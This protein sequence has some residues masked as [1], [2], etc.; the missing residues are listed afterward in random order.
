MFKRIFTIA[1]LYLKTTYS[2]R[3]TL[4]FSLAMPLLFTFV[5]AQAMANDGPGE[6]QIRITLAVVDEDATA[7]SRAFIDRLEADPSV[8][9]RP[10]EKEAA[11]EE[12][13]D[14]LSAAVLIPSGFEAGLTAGE[15]VELLFYQNSNEISE[16]Q[17]LMEAV[18]A[19]AGELAGSFAAADIATRVAGRLGMFAESNPQVVDSYRAEAFTNAEVEWEAGAPVVVE[20]Q[21]V[22]RLEQGSS[23]PNGASQSSPG[24]LVM[25]ALF[26]TFGGGA[27]LLVERDE[28][29]LRRLLVMP[30]GKGTLMAGKMLGIYLGALVQMAIMVLA[31]QFA[32]GVEWGQDPAALVVMLLAYGL[33]GTSLGLLLAAL[34][35]TAAQV[36]AAGTIIMMALSS[37]GGAWWPIEI[38][39]RYMQSLALALPTGWAM[40]GFHDIIT[41]GL[42]LADILLETAVLVG[43]AALFFGIGIWRFKYE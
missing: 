32:F 22:S 21:T 29:T 12:L 23:I 14:V 4:I 38:V 8:N 33:T 30:M 18:N 17:L 13:E 2:S 35:K 16:A 5:L 34:S 25:Y 7:T 28:G 37:L 41:R 3:V 40:R 27:S 6:G 36:S 1:I 31:G 42:G 10:F 19:A 15:D 20:T 26:F 9:V 24:M 11:L 43:F 39:P